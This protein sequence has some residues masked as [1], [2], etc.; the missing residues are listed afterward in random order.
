MSMLYYIYVDMGV[1]QNGKT[2]PAC[3]RVHAYIYIIIIY[4]ILYILL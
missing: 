4:Y 3:V 1:L 2:F